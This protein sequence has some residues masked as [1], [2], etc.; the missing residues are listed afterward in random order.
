MDYTTSYIL[1]IPT[2]LYMGFAYNLLS[3]IHIQALK[4]LNQLNAP[5]IVARGILLFATVSQEFSFHPVAICVTYVSLRPQRS[6]LMFAP[7]PVILVPP[8]PVPL[9][10][11]GASFF[12]DPTLLPHYIPDFVLT[13][14]Y[15]FYPILYPT[16]DIYMVPVCTL[17]SLL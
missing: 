11:L 6:V 14:E 13:S 10:S 7:K 16:Q 9:P 4:D 17:I 12:L 8:L 2:C 3:Q 5:A 1:N 15:R